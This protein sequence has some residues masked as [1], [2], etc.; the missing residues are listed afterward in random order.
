MGLPEKN[1][2]QDP[3][4]RVD[5]GTTFASVAFAHSSSPDEVKLVRTWL[6]ARAG[7]ET[8]DQVPSEV[9][10]R[11]PITRGMTWGY[12]IPDDGASQVL[13]WFKLLLQDQRDAPKAPQD[14]GSGQ[15][16]LDLAPVT[17][18]PAQATAKALLELGISP[19]KVITDFLTRVRKV[20]LASIDSTYGRN[21]GGET[22]I[23]YVLTIPAIWSDMS[24]S[25]MVQAAQGAGFGT[26]RVDFVLMGEPESAAVYTLKELQPDNLIVGDTC[27]ICD[28]GGGTVDLISYQ[29][30]ALNPLRL[31]EVVSGSGGMHGSV[32]LDHGFERYIREKLGDD[33]IDSMKPRARK[34]MMRTW[35]E[36]VKFKFGNTTTFAYDVSVHGV[37]DNEA[38]NVDD[39]EDV[40]RIFDPVVDRI[41]DLVTQQVQGVQRKGFNVK[42]ILLVGGF[43]SSAYLLQRLQNI[44]CGLQ[45]LQPP[46]AR[47]AIARGALVR[48]LDGSIVKQKRSR[49]HYGC[50]SYTKYYPD[51]G[52]DAHAYW[53]SVEECWNVSGKLTW[54]LHKNDEVGD[55]MSTSFPFYRAYSELPRR[56]VFTETLTACD[57]DAA[58]EFQWMDPTAI[59]S[60]CEVEADLSRIPREKFSRTTAPSGKSYYVVSYEIRMSLVADVLRFEVVFEGRSQ[61]II[62]V[63]MKHPYHSPSFLE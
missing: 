49:R 3:P 57:S 24:K 20:A 46:N 21:L 39:G 9:H 55:E 2:P 62:K 59:Y 7:D 28:A 61:G 52:W 31:D 12:E 19:V 54:F 53:D 41:V 32:Y 47:T 60:V 35:A 15:T 8:A 29:I 18:N 34:E 58:P 63:R 37:P 30:T 38:T 56:L 43:G 17:T 50:L 44:H 33:V 27:I 11:N 10:Y 16:K 40:K 4:F 22:R 14:R 13:K 25:L 42:A 26:H 6:N 1:Q 36:N 51:L 23:E 48:G 5:F 45:V